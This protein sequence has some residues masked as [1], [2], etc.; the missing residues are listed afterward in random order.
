MNSP[1]YEIHPYSIET[2]RRL[3]A[4]KSG[5]SVDSVQKK[6]HCV[7]FNNYF[8]ELSAKT[9]IVE[10]SYV[11]RDFLEDYAAYYVRCFNPYKRFCSRL[12]F[13]NIPITKNKFDS[14]L[15]GRTKKKT[16]FKKFT[17]SYLGFVVVKPLP[18]TIIG[19]TCLKTYGSDNGRRFYPIIRCNEV[20][21]FG[22]NL[23]VKSLA[24]QEQDKVVAACA[25]SALWST[26]QGTGM[27]FQ[28]P[29]LSPVEI[30]K[31]ACDH[32]PLETRAIPNQ[33]LS[34][35]LIAHAIRNVNLEP[36]LVK[37]L[38]HEIL[39]ANIYA[40][41]KMGIPLLLGIK[42]VD[43]S[44]KDDNEIGYHAVAVTGYSL[45]LDAPT[46][47]IG[48]FLT[49]SAQID[50]IYV[51][52]DQVGPF[53]RMGLEPGDILSTSYIGE[54]GNIGSVG[55][56]PWI[57]FIPLYHKIR[58]PLESIRASVV[59]FDQWVE[60]FRDPGL[61]NLSHRLV[62]DIH[63]TTINKFKKSV[64]DSDYTG[65]R[66]RRDILLSKMP[67]FLW[68]AT[69]FC[70]QEPV[71]DLLFDATDIEHGSFLTKVIPYYPELVEVFKIIKSIPE[72][73]QRIKSG[74]AWRILENNCF[75]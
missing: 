53:S 59:D 27:M 30:T 67:R 24:F 62:W 49:R 23:R 39:Q 34:G 47:I 52:D 11:D 65:I 12:H 75:S 19:R 28:H 20:N 18:E 54:D 10:N 16:Y 2:L 61:I 72:L 71:L 56:I 35:H 50:K 57:I 5:N 26:F 15:N 7:Y 22:L 66:D 14:M 33:G 58:I 41:C 68:R 55:A 4:E 70:G 31:A 9:I 74:P 44:K 8:N 3:L 69:A 29:I 42:L 37:T 51:H 1:A 40:Y 6:I 73:A 64:L 43:L 63:L 17:E 38:D 36:Y 25:T 21:L 13:F 46:P 32:M 45:G 60:I 48:G